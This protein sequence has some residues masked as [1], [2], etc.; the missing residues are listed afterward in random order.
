ML[1][2]SILQYFWPA[3]SDNRSWKPILVFFLSGPF[4]QV[5]LYL[6]QVWIFVMDPID[7]PHSSFNR[8]RQLW[9]HNRG[10]KFH[11]SARNYEWNLER[12]SNSSQSTRP[13]GQ[14]YRTSAFER[15]TQGSRITY[16]SL[17]FFIAHAFKGH[18]HVFAGR[19]KVVSH[20]S[21][22]TSAISKYFCPLHK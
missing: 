7:W 22:R 4:R 19:V 6:K 3:L 17:M 5:L 16:Y 12:T 1:L 20:S 9:I 10:Q 18:V 14:E 8:M 21:C 13:V 2:W 15:I 11:L